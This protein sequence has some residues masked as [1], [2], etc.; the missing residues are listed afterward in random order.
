MV[1]SFDQKYFEDFI[2]GSG[3]IHILFVKADAATMSSNI[4]FNTM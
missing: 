3:I 1:Q 4:K 2:D